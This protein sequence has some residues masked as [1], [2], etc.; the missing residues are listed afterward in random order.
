MTIKTGD[1]GTIAKDGTSTAAFTNTKDV[2]PPEPDTGNLTVSKVVAGNAGDQQK[3][4]NFTV[5]LD[6]DSIN[7]AFGGMTFTNGVATFTLK[8]GESK[9]AA[10]LPAGITYTVAEDDYSGDGYVRR[11]ALSRVFSQTRNIKAMLYAKRP[12]L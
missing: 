4:F 3:D 8:H 11:S 1:T 10:N 6:D 7:G 9:T 5:T 12:I 2:T